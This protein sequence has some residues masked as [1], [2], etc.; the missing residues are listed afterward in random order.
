MQLLK[1]Q[2]KMDRYVR[3]FDI[4]LFDQVQVNYIEIHAVK[5][6]KTC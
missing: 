5:Q 4:G 3:P 6:M 1:N 2:L